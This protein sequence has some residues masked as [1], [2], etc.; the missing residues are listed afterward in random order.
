M[1]KTYSWVCT[2]KGKMV[3]QEFDL[4][5]I[6]PD[7]LLM[8]VRMVTICGSDPHYLMD[9]MGNTQFPQI[10][11]HEMVGTVYQAGERAK[12]NY[13]VEIGDRITVEPYIPCG[14][15]QNCLSGYYQ[16]CEHGTR[17]YGC[18][19][20]CSEPP[21]LW[22]AYGEYMY[23][24]PGSMVHKVPAWIQDEDVVLSS[25]IGN[26]YRFIQ[27]KAQLKANESVLILGP[28]AMGLA[29]VIA[30]KECG[31]YPIIVTGVGEKDAPRL[32]LAE[33]YGADYTIRID[34]EDAAARILEITNGKGVNAVI[35][36]SGAPAA[37]NLAFQA[38]AAKATLVIVGVVGKA[39]IH[40]DSD[41]IMRKEL[42]IKGSLGQPLDVFEA[43]KTIGKKKYRIDKMVTHKFP[44]S[45][46]DKAIE[47]F[48]EHSSECI[49]VAICAEE[50]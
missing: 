48:M 41:L 34:K 33:E 14:T 1:A 35:E 20:S 19:I 12:K 50:L 46:A 13:Q 23:V 6:G 37:Y 39:G 32:A 18:T 8:K 36:C 21:H 44:M 47:F 30:A 28:G 40:F 15:C 17:A 27:K 26:G 9:H 45:Q 49:R 7:D 5:E 3:R 2:E 43:M 4:P 11:G 38:M 24:A 22:G 42:Q 29:T 31:V 10:L 16:L 25:N